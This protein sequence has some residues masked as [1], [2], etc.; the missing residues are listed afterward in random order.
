[1]LSVTA[2]LKILQDLL[3]KPLHDCDL[4][5]LALIQLKSEGSKKYNE[6]VRSLCRKNGC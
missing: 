2:V 1:M 5:Y 4:N 6:I 3:A